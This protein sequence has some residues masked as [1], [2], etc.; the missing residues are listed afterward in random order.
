MHKYITVLDYLVSS[1][2]PSQILKLHHGPEK[3][4]SVPRYVLTESTISGP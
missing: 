1:P 2:G 3:V 4:D